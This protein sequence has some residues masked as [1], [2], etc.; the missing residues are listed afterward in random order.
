MKCGLHE[1]SLL[2]GVLVGAFLREPSR[3]INPQKRYASKKFHVCVCVCVIVWLGSLLVAYVFVL[4]LVV[5]FHVGGRGREESASE[6]DRGCTSEQA[7]ESVSEHQ[8]PT[9]CPK[10]LAG[11]PKSGNLHPHKATPSSCESRVA[12]TVFQERCWQEPAVLSRGSV[13]LSQKACGAALSADR[14]MRMQ[15]AIQ[16]TSKR[17]PA[18]CPHSLSS[19]R[20]MGLVP[21]HACAAP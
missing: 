9:R 19:C 7:S 18:F 2:A 14:A 5:E 12:K 6:R 15:W 8:V 10:Q 1:P 16:M 3:Y 13:F 17:A 11:C 21:S 4:V 20:K